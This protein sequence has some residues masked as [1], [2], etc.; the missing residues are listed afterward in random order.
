MTA[1]TL[2]G[3]FILLVA[4]FM[5]G[6]MA[7]GYFY[8]ESQE[9]KIR[10]KETLIES[11][12]KGQTAL[13]EDI[14][15]FER[16]EK[17]VVLKNRDLQDQAKTFEGQKSMILNQVRTSVTGFESFRASATEEIA[18]LKATVASLE[19]EKT[20][21]QG[22]L[23]S[24]QTSS[25]S[26]KEQ[27]SSEIEDLGKKI[28]RLKST[29]VKLVENLNKTDKYAMA[30]ETAKLHYNLGNFYFKNADYRDA[31]D[32]YK[33]SLFYNPDDAD[34][35]FNLAM[36]SENF[37]NDLAAAMYRYRR[38]LDLKPD[39]KDR[40]TVTQKIL[41]LQL[42]QEVIFDPVKQ[43]DPQIFKNEG[44]E[45]SKFDMIGDKN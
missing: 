33:K 31:A 5:A 23:E 10:E 22:K 45:M 35:N 41:D 27:M 13:K 7:A 20:D 30:H 25:S 36:V 26:E 40:K 18:K 39:A 42:R 38:Y 16:R 9:N 11:L 14:E 19:A 12:K 4:L 37:L 32:E 43:K 6:V 44:K 24:L 1:R 21:T 17:E 34:A 3:I 28:D 29:E 2:K 8:I 15:K